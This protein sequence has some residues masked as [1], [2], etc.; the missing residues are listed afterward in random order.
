[1][2][3]EPMTSRPSTTAPILAMLGIVLVTAMGCTEDR[4]ERKSTTLTNTPKRSRKT[5][6]L[7]DETRRC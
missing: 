6:S 3:C 4:F 5:Q 2:G 7:P 1:M